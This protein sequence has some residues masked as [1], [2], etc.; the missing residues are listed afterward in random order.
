MEMAEFSG[1]SSEYIEHLKEFG[2]I[3]KGLKT[4]F[5]TTELQLDY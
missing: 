2:V 1:K 3:K 5:T 4:H